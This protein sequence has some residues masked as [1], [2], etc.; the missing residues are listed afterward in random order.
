MKINKAGKDLIQKNE[1][2][3]LEAYSDIGGIATIGWGHTG[4]EVHLG[5]TW[6][7]K[8][9]D[10][11]FEQDLSIFEEGVSKL[12]KVPLT[13]NQFGALVSLAYN[14]GLGAFAHSGCLLYLNQGNFE[15]SMGSLLHW[16]KVNGVVS[17]GLA[18]RR[19]EEKDL[20]LTKDTVSF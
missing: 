20:F 8:Q 18:R 2:C 19:Q 9:C 7:Q 13:S 11:Q 16:D 1:S 12:V 3:R 5:L 17:K 10:V 14:I 15:R 6:T 4:Q